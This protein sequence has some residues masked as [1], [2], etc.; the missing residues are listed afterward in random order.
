MKQPPYTANSFAVAFQVAHRILSLTAEYMELVKRFPAPMVSIKGVSHCFFFLSL[1]SIERDQSFLM[2]ADVCC[3]RSRQQS[4]MAV[5]TGAAMG[6]DSFL[7]RFCRRF[8]SIPP[9]DRAEA[10][11]SSPVFQFARRFLRFYIR[12]A[13]WLVATVDGT[14]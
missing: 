8:E 14:E 2:R 3:F 4:L 7:R 5:K 6:S 12:R 13:K 1:W 11:S 9:E 10:L